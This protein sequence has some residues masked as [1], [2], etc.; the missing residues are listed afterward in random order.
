MSPCNSNLSTLHLVFV[1]SPGLK[2]AVTFSLPSREG[3]RR[4]CPFITNLEQQRQR[5]GV[6]RCLNK[7]KPGRNINLRGKDINSLGKNKRGIPRSNCVTYSSR[8]IVV[9]HSE[10]NPPVALGNTCWLE[11]FETTR[12]HTLWV[13]K[14]CGAFWVR[15]RPGEGNDSTLC[16]AGCD[17]FV[18]EFVRRASLD[19]HT[20]DGKCGYELTVSV[21]E[22]FGAF[23]GYCLRFVWVWVCFL[24]LCLSH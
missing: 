2:L 11:T 3:K 14:G 13:A 4:S 23:C 19:F 9:L 22:T 1:T 18:C 20:Q 21:F 10:T 6:G 15:A 5:F 16:V 8:S 17:S 7:S 12:G 24:L